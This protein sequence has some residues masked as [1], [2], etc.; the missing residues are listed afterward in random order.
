MGF[1]LVGE[2][3]RGGS[4]WACHARVRKV[5][6]KGTI[7]FPAGS[8][9]SVLEDT[10]MACSDRSGVAVEPF[11]CTPRNKWPTDVDADQGLPLGG[12]LG[13]SRTDPGEQA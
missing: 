8:H 9:P 5:L 12:L 2:Q 13:E 11:R 1:P 7:A 3:S 6:R 10:C 4:P